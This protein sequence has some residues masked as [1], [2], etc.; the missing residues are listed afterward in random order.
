MDITYKNEGSNIYLTY[1]FSDMDKIDT[2]S[3]GM[4]TNNKIPGLA[5]T[6]FAQFDMNEYVKF[7]V[8]SKVSVSQVLSG[9]VN[10]KRLLGIFGGVI[11]AIMSAEEYMIDTSSI[12]L[13]TDYIFTDVTTCETVLICLPLVTEKS[14]LNMHSFF[15][16]IMFNTQFD[17]TEN[18]DYV[19]QIINY[20]NSSAVFSITEFKALLDRINSSSSVAQNSNPVGT[21]SQKAIYVNDSENVTAQQSSIQK[22]VKTT[23]QNNFNQSIKQKSVI[24]PPKNDKDIDQINKPYISPVSETESPVPITT[25][26]GKVPSL[27]WLMMHY[28]KE[29]KALYDASKKAQKAQKQVGSSSNNGREISNKQKT[30]GFAIPGK[31]SNNG[32]AIPGKE[33]GYEFTKTEQ[34]ISVPNSE[35]KSQMQKFQQS[36]NY[37]NLN[38]T[39][40]SVSFGETTVLDSGNVGET[41]VLNQPVFQKVS[42]PF[43]IRKKNNE[44]IF[45]DKPIFK[46]GK[47]KSYVDYFIS[48]NTAISR[49][50]ATIMS[51]NGQYFIIDTNS[52]N[53]TYLNGEMIQSNV[54]TPI[55]D[56]IK[57]RLANEEFEFKLC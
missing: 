32:F 47:E 36:Y 8:T 18:C 48:D 45:I 21:R 5:Q 25:P 39:E 19:A 53:H 43:L 33:R 54:M 24:S 14:L 26:D 10:K 6:I 11:S 17:Q 29:N 23:S 1:K 57:I 52:T 51:Q 37:N 20:L 38:S 9:V 27:M 41:T 42:K 56:G 3:L 31:E 46:I 49:S 2:L 30:N 28:S 13:D 7:N 40:Q 16:N 44:H 15:K 22:E 12:L 55:M 4:L 50:H 34:K 35:S